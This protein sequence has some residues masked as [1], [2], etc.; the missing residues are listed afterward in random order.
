MLEIKHKH[1]L[2]ILYTSNKPTIKQALID[3]NLSGANLDG[4]YL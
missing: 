4:A 3:A 2:D 1:S